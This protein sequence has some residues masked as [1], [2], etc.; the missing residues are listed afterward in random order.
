MDYR[1][2][3]KDVDIP[4]VSRKEGGRRLASIEDSVDIDKHR[5]RLI[6]ST[7]NHTDNQRINRTE[8]TRKQNRKKNNSM[9]V[10]S[11]YQVTYH[12][13]KRGGDSERE[14]LRDPLF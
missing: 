1:T 9:D 10:L 8:I 7:R 14:T 12:T 5:G 11:D 2:K 13:S 4:Y 3:I 6:T